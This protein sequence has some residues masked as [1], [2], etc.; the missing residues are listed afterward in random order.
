MLCT[1]RF[2]EGNSLSGNKIGVSSLS[3]KLMGDLLE[4]RF[5]LLRRVVFTG[6]SNLLFGICESGFTF[7]GNFLV[8]QIWTEPCE[9][10][11]NGHESG[12]ST[13]RCR[14]LCLPTSDVRRGKAMLDDT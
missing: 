5:T 13:V 6:P 3:L 10:P 12:R 2:L 9:L 1:C 14:D 4:G 11:R 8:S 7:V